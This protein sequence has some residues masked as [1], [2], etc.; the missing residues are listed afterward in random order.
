MAIRFLSDIA[1]GQKPEKILT[2]IARRSISLL[3]LFEIASRTLSNVNNNFATVLIKY[4][5]VFQ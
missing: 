2:V 3:Q 5:Y 4:L 1:K